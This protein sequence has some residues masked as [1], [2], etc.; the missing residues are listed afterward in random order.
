MTE[1][2]AAAATIAVRSRFR[3]PISSFVSE[4]L[5][6]FIT[7]RA[8]NGSFCL[9]CLIIS[10]IPT[11]PSIVSGFATGM[12]IRSCSLLFLSSLPVRFSCV[13][14]RRAA[15]SVATEL[16][17][18]VNNIITTVPFNTSSFNKRSPFS[19]II[20]C[21]INTAANV[22]AACALLNPNI[23]LRSTFCMPY[24]F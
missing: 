12:R 6:S 9:G 4:A 20:S 15:L 17:M 14:I 8:T 21:P 24:I 18:Q 22:A 10:A 5:L 19:M 2:S 3:L 1:A 11:N 7:L 23:R 16:M 13:T